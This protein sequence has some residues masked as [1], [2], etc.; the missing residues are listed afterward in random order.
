MSEASESGLVLRREGDSE[1]SEVLTGRVAE[2]LSS[3]SS[4]SSAGGGGGGGGEGDGGD[5][6]SEEVD[7]GGAGG[8][9]EGEE[10]DDRK[11]AVIK[12]ET[13]FKEADEFVSALSETLKL[14]LTQPTQELESKVAEVEKLFERIEQTVRKQ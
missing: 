14:D 9:G 10:E 1:D 7:G 3:S 11:A 8:G 4:T 12:A 2:T 13:F 5:A 6:S